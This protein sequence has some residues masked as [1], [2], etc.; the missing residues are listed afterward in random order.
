MSD[1]GL[2]LTP[3]LNAAL[4]LAMHD[5][6]LPDEVRV[7]LAIARISWGNWCAYACQRPTPPLQLPPEP[8]A[9]VRSFAFGAG[10][11]PLCRRSARPDR[12]GMPRNWRLHT[13]CMAKAYAQD[14][15]MYGNPRER[16]WASGLLA[17]ATQ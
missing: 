10:P 15:A 13:W 1:T 7:G 14:A 17:G 8:E 2:P 9:S 12:E 5:T 4:E 3:L 16:E 6:S 11:C